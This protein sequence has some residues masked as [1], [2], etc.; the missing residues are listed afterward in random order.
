[1][2]VISHSS[3][4]EY[5]N[6]CDPEYSKREPI[7]Q[8]LARISYDINQQVYLEVHKDVQIANTN[9]TDNR[10][11]DNNLKLTRIL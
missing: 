3:Y 4:K 6:L 8:R 7:I 10:I 1:M 5:Q 2:H 9:D 11:F